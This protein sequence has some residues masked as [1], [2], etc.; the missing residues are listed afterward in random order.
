[1]TASVSL[2]FM[3]ISGASGSLVTEADYVIPSTG[4][5][6]H[7]LRGLTRKAGTPGLQEF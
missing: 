4:W 3:Y 6:S 5:K 2:M 1:M 7:K